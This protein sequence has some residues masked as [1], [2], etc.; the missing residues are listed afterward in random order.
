MKKEMEKTPRQGAA[1]T[2]R[3]GNGCLPPSQ[4]ETSSCAPGGGEAGTT[5]ASSGR[6]SKQE[7]NPVSRVIPDNLCFRQTRD[8]QDWSHGSPIEPLYV[9]HMWGQ[10]F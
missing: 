5:L 6:I 1:V 2:G 7:L 9:S 3:V 10:T 4:A 8:T